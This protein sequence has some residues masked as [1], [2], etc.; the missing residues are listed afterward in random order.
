MK[1]LP[2]HPNPR[3]RA[4]R[5]PAGVPAASLFYWATRLFLQVTLSS[6]WK[7]R[8]FDR[9]REPAEGGAVYVCNHQSF[10]D[11]PLMSFALRRPM[12]YMA[13]HTLFHMPGFRHLIEA[14]NAFP[15]HRGTADTGAMKEAMRR[16]KA[17]GQVVVFPEGTRTRDGRIGPFLPG[18]VL[19]CRRAAEWTVPVQIEGAFDAWPRWQA[20]PSPGE[21]TVRYGEPISQAEARAMRPEALL[22]RIR[23]TILAMQRDTRRRLGKP[24]LAYAET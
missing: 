1:G 19:L 10:L 21:I 8:V 18:T 24:P 6:F 2:S 14:L 9:H 22:H 11:P 5:P 20:L 16:L 23:E 4:F 7:V 3:L 12:N 13:R 17:G 15:V